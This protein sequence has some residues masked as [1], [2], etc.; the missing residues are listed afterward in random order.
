VNVRNTAI[1]LRRQW[2][3]AIFLAMSMDQTAIAAELS[4]LHW[5]VGSWRGSLGPQTVEEAWSEPSGGTMSTMIRL[6]SATETLMVE[7]VVIREEGG[8]LVLHLRQ[9]DPTLQL[10]M[11][12]DM[13]LAELTPQGV[14]FAGTQDAAI[15]MLA[16]R[17]I[18]PERMEV[19]V[20]TA[21]G[22]VMT[23]VLQRK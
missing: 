14:A 18:N 20:T 4:E 15:K 6:T 22:T 21:D 23:A 11:A 10:V 19:D 1:L 12:Q 3:C 9:F 16:Y 2:V 5:M 7:L 8:S 17:N 13:T